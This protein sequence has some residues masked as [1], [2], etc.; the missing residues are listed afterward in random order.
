METLLLVMSWVIQVL[1]S[2]HENY[3][4]NE[5]S[6]IEPEN[7]FL[8]RSSPQIPLE[9]HTTD[10]QIKMVMALAKSEIEKR[11]GRSS[12]VKYKFDLN[13]LYACMACTPSQDWYLKLHWY[14]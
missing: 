2:Y 3:I 1:S 5:T 12:A 13:Q 7:Q 14:I 11:F 6:Y 10:P 9:G 4:Y 8:Y